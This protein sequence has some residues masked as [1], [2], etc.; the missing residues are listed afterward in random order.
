ME[1]ASKAEQKLKQ[2]CDRIGVT[3][4]GRNWLDICLD[5]F[6]DIEQHPSGYP[7]KQ[8]ARSCVQVVHDTLT[9][10]V[11][12]GVSGNWD[13]NIFLD[14][15]WE[16]MSLYDTNSLSGIE[17]AFG[18][19]VGSPHNRGGLVVRAAA[20]G[21]PLTMPTTQ[22]AECRSL[23]TDVFA[24]TTP[25]RLLGLGFEVHDTTQEL[26]KQGA[27]VV[28][29][30]SDDNVRLQK[31][32]GQDTVTP[33]VG[34]VNDCVVL[35]EPPT[36]QGQAIDL[37]L[38][39]EWLAKDGCYVVP[40]LNTTTNPPDYPNRLG[41]ESV[42]GTQTLVSYYPLIQTTGA[43]RYMAS[44]N[45]ETPFSLSGAYFTGL[46][47]AAV[48]VVNLCYYIEQFP[49]YSSPLHRLTKKG[50]PLDNEAIELYTKI[51]RVMPCGVPVN[52]NFL[53]AFI[54][55]IANIARTVAPHIGTAL[56][57]GSA[58]ATALSP[59][60]HP[61]THL[62]DLYRGNDIRPNS[63]LGGNT[64]QSSST[65]RRNEIVVVSP[66]RS[67]ASV[68]RGTSQPNTERAI[69]PYTPILDTLFPNQRREVE[70]EVVREMRQNPNPQI[71][72]KNKR[73]KEY[74]RTNELIK[75]ATMPDAGNKW[76]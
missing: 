74:S 18:Q 3:S 39:Q 6:K 49:A 28:Y 20:Q 31:A 56:R 1:K 46:D 32:H 57:V 67:Q 42:D 30:V 21:T 75:K 47:P 53:G 2:L 63:I 52:D 51:A 54:S 24:N 41:A 34:S 72:V 45:L 14:T 26:K 64:N 60:V 5:P 12:S 29:R 16:N 55:G 76:G 44:A 19:V 7:D 13:C 66:Q 17:F 15:L 37:P 35:P 10:T 11:P 23:V 33:V 69:I 25:C 27:V 71:R 43:T 73:K 50:C 65:Q 58:L 70:R 36:T 48:L 8:L 59:P 62:N 38:S 40:V 68:S 22:N 4:E 9:L 61:N